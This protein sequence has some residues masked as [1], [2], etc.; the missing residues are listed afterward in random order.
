MSPPLSV[1]M[2]AHDEEVFVAEAIESILGQTFSEYEFIIIDDGSTDATHEVISRYSD[3]RIRLLSNEKNIGLSR[4]LNRGLE[5]C[6][7]ELIARMDANDLSDPSRFER[8]LAA[9]QSRP[10]LDLVWTGASYMTRTGETLCPKRSPPLREVIEL[11]ASSPTPLPAGR[12]HVNHVTVMFRRASVM[13]LGGYSEE[14]PLGQDGNL[15]YRM[16][17]SGAGFDFID[18][19]LMRIR[20]LTQGVSASRRGHTKIDENEYY[21]NICRLNRHYR[22]ALRQAARMPWSI[23]KLRLMASTLKQRFVSP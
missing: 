1:L 3:R 7:G 22:Q 11:L 13:R 23:G 15:W 8:Q 16:L 21:A 5:V 6:R 4:S 18:D 20:L 10:D 12:N 9:F 14:Y 2:S 19:S 17:Q